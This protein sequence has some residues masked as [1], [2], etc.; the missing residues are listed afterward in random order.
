MT[1]VEAANFLRLLMRE[2][3]DVK[4][5]VTKIVDREGYSDMFDWAD[6]QPDDIIALAESL[7]DVSD[8]FA[9]FSRR[10]ESGDLS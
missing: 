3:A 6:Q 8:Q 1:A 7:T 10:L 5:M 4:I 2:D 9:E